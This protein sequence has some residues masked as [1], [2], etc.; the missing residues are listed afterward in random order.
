MGGR[1]PDL[2]VVAKKGYPAKAAPNTTRDVEPPVSGG[3]EWL[4]G[5]KNMAGKSRKQM[6]EEM[7]TEEPND[8]ELRYALAMEYV[9]A[10]DDAG[11]VRCFQE[12]C[13]AQPDFV[14]TYFHLAQALIR[15]DRSEEARPVVERG[16]A[17]ARNKGDLHA[18]GELEGL[19]Y[20][21]E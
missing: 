19:L 21:L 6:I 14:P 16:I 12:L 20:S 13:A 5:G 1:L 4:W 7:L 10:Q 17:A 8:P 15:L 2:P 9:S 11:A 3:R 18:A